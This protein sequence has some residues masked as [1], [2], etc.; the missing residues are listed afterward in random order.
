MEARKDGMYDVFSIDQR[1]NY[2]SCNLLVFITSG[3]AGIVSP[4]SFEGGAF[5]C[6]FGGH[7]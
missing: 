2:P 4:S 5:Y 3:T 7:I 6:S 1:F